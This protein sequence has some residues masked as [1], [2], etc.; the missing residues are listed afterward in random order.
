MSN[1]RQV[2]QVELD[3]NGT[4]FLASPLFDESTKTHVQVVL[5]LTAGLIA[6]KNDKIRPTEDDLRLIAVEPST[7]ERP[8][9]I[10]RFDVDSL[11]D[12]LMRRAIA[13]EQQ[14][15]HA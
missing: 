6:R 3:S 5:E 8:Y 10:Y 14:E 15:T 13:Q 2:A 11:F 9:T 1:C 12:I 7:E 4:R